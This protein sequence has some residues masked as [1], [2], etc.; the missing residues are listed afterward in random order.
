MRS[1]SPSI[2][3]CLSAMLV[4]A[5]AGHVVGLRA[6]HHRESGEETDLVATSMQ[7]IDEGKVMSTLWRSCMIDRSCSL[8]SIAP[9]MPHTLMLPVTTHSFPVL[10]SDAASPGIG[11]VSFSAIDAIPERVYGQLGSWQR[12]FGESILFS[13]DPSSVGELR[14]LVAFLPPLDN[15]TGSKCRVLYGFE[16]FGHSCGEVTIA[17]GDCV[18]QHAPTGT[19]L[20]WGIMEISGGQ[21]GSSS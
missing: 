4:G 14:F 1:A 2:F 7:M 21:P 10:F 16:L 9:G 20:T 17:F 8:W 13:I 12:Q 3:A 5:L 6:K 15:V 11:A 18:L 19:G